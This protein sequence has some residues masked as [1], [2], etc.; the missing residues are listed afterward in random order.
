M[1][2]VLYSGFEDC[3]RGCECD[4]ELVKWYLFKEGPA[5]LSCKKARLNM[6]GIANHVVSVT[7]IQFCFYSRRAA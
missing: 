5:N 4:R 1:I 6:S 3:R 2:S 7:D